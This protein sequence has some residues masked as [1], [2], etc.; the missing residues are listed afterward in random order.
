MQGDYTAGSLSVYGMGGVSSIVYSNQ[1]HF[2]VANEKVIAPAISATQFKGGAMFNLQD[3]F[4]V[5]GNFGIVGKPPILDNVIDS[6]GA[7]S[8]DPINEKFVS[9]EMGLNF[10]AGM[11]AVTANVYN[12]NWKDRNLTRSV[13]TGAG[14]SGD[15]DIIYLTGVNQ[16]HQGLEI[17]ASAQLM[18]MLRIDAAVSLG[19]WKFDEDAV[20]EYKNEAGDLLGTYNYALKELF[21]GDMPQTSFV[22]GATVTPMKGLRLQVIDSY[23]TKNYANWSPT[24]RSYDTGTAEADIDREQVWEAPSY[25][26]MDIH[27]SYNLPKIAGLDLNFFVHV[28]NALDATYVQDA[29]DNS[30]YNGY[31]G[32]SHDADN[33]EVFL[34]TERFFNTGIKIRF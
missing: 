5:F 22:F 25:N 1:N 30:P 34:G 18:D 16:T 29:L 7:V 20:G 15:T 32:T 21:V 12:T 6:D 24:S 31:G 27:A 26:K 23:Y 3:N 10:N 28:F 14:D 13:V 2:T 11:F 33:A 4:S 9:A 8:S 19:N 17:E